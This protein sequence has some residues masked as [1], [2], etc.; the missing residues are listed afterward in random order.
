VKIMSPTD[1]TLLLLRHAQ[2]AEFA[3]GRGDHERPLTD[4][5]IEQAEAVGSAIRS[6]GISIDHVICSSALRTRQTFHALGL[7]ATCEFTRDAYNA[8]SESLLELVRLLPEEVG[9]AML[10]GHGPGVPAL[11][12]DLA[13]P[14]SDQR[15]VDVLNSRYPTATLASIEIVGSWADL[16]VGR[17]DWLRVG[18]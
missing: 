1:H 11:A 3:P 18:H 2:A 16:S 10:I 4:Y 12:S 7:D 13:G 17:L 5:G 8:G 9:T 14:G 15:S 6:R